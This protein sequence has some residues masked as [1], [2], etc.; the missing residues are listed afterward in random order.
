MINP[1]K[2]IPGEIVIAGIAIG[3]VIGVIG[4]E[5]LTRNDAP[6]WD[7]TYMHQT[8]TQESSESVLVTRDGKE[9][10][11]YAVPKDFTCDDL[12]HARE[13]D[14][15]SNPSWTES[16]EAWRGVRGIGRGE[17]IKYLSGSP[18]RVEDS[19]TIVSII[20]IEPEDILKCN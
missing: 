6:S 13:I 16:R 3:S 19:G 11:V 17:E 20:G 1:L 2:K 14:N 15:Q 8:S 10:V 5:Y 4:L 7:Q 9:Y 12:Y 18:A